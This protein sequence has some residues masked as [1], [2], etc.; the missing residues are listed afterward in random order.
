MINRYSIKKL[1]ELKAAFNKYEKFEEKI[2][3][4]YEELKENA[5]HGLQY[6]I[7]RKDHCSPAWWKTLS[8][9]MAENEFKENGFRYHLFEGAGDNGADAYIE[10]FWS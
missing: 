5:K 3:C 1:K 8:S 9:K 7:L 10:I 6:Y 2:N 4:T